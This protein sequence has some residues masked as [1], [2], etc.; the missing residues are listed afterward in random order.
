MATSDDLLADIRHLAGIVNM[1]E[2]QNIEQDIRDKLREIV[3]AAKHRFKST[4]PEDLSDELE[5][6]LKKASLQKPP[7]LTAKQHQAVASVWDVLGSD[8]AE[9]EAAAGRAL[10][11][12]SEGLE[13]RPEKNRLDEKAQAEMTKTLESMQRWLKGAFPTVNSYAKKMQAVAAS[14]AADKAIQA[15]VQMVSDTLQQMVTCL[16][17]LDAASKKAL[18]G[19]NTINN[20]R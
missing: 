11:L 18:G 7:A 10:M 14:G 12:M 3:T 19:K 2:G 15:E 1:Y 16:T 13:P 5:E 6:L 8:I 17:R 4:K 9:V 20:E